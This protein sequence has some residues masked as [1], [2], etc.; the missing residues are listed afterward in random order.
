MSA[1]NNSLT[2][3]S[4]L[5]VGGRICENLLKLMNLFCFTSCGKVTAAV[6]ECF[7]AAGRCGPHPDAAGFVLPALSFVLSGEQ[8]IKLNNTAAA[9]LALLL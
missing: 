4:Y 6:R 2:G 1:A 7:G 3:S 5:N 9:A 8:R